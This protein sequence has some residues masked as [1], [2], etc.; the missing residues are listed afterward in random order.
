MRNLGDEGENQWREKKKTT[1]M[2]EISV[3]NVIASWSSDMRLTATPPLV[4][5]KGL[6]QCYLF[7]DLKQIILLF[8][9]KFSLENTAMGLD[10]LVG[11]SINDDEAREVFE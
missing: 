9:T 2:T 11:E 4:P 5:I 7:N 3:T 8:R 1:I 6:Y 10:F